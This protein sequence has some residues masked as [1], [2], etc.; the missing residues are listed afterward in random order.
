[1]ALVYL[2]CL[3]PS[4][5]APSLDGLEPM[6]DG[7]PIQLAP[8]GQLLAVWSEVG[9][10]FD[11]ARLNASIRDLDWLSPRAVRHHQVVDELYARAKPLLPLSFGAIFRSLASLE[12]RLSQ[13]QAGLLARLERLRGCDEWNL[14]LS[15]DQAVFNR[16][17][18]QASPALS[19]SLAQL[20]AKPPGT[21]FLLEK[22]IH[23]LQAQEAQ[24]ISAGVRADVHQAIEAHAVEAHRDQLTAPAAADN[25][26]L[27]L[28]AAYLL[29]ES[30]VEVAQR[31]VA[32]LE[33][34]YRALGY[35]LEFSGPWPPFTFARGLQEALS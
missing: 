29:R 32:E 26:R 18:G 28:R 4:G 5:A 10:E 23:T 25:Q 13:D 20:A 14:K 17:L 30:A 6:E 11:E 12:Q 15:R 19:A 35:A 16:E 3:L 24:R 22:K 33:A 7:L 1:M 31:T 21:R 9:D 8:A 2:Y 34:R 27:E